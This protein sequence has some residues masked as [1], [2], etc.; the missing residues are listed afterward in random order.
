MK[1]YIKELE[2]HK[3]QFSAKRDKID[4]EPETVKLEGAK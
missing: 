4:R 2:K 3:S 1:D